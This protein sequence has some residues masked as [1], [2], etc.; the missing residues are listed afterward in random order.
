MDLIWYGWENDYSAKEVAE[1]LN[2]SKEEIENVYHNFERK[3]KTT[4][5]LRQIPIIDNY[6]L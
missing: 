4:E 2:F 6:I 3:K 5:Y 1:V